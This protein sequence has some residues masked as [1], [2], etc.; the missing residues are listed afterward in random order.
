M[1]P[2]AIHAGYDI[3]AGIM[4]YESGIAD[5]AEVIELFQHLVDSG[6]AW[7]LQGAYGRAATRM[8]EQGLINDA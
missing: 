5:E 4:R 6:L 3:V 1:A 2:N 8:I 7:S